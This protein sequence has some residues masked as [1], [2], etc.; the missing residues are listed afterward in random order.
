MQAVCRDVTKLQETSSLFWCASYEL[1]SCPRVCG[2]VLNDCPLISLVIINSGKL[3][4]LCCKNSLFSKQ[5]LF[6][7]GVTS[8]CQLQDVLLNNSK[9]RWE[10]NDLNHQACFWIFLSTNP[11]P[12][13]KANKF[14]RV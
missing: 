5:T 10:A 4:Y 8:I 2:T 3:S 7:F 11:V 9:S 1:K 13:R 12:K 14:S 6:L